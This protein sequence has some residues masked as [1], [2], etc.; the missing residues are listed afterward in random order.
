M[1]IYIFEN[2]SQTDAANFTTADSLLF[3][4]PTVSANT[5]T[6]T[7]STGGNLT[8]ITSAGKTLT[9]GGN[10]IANAAG[11]QFSDSSGAALDLAQNGNETVAGTTGA[12]VIYGFDGTDCIQADTGNDTLFGAAG[13]DTLLGQGGNDQLDGGSGVDQINGDTGND[14]IFGGTGADALTGLGGADHIYGFGLGADATAGDGADT[15]D[16]GDGNDYGQ[17]NLGNDTIEG[18]LGS[19][20]I[21][22]GADNDSITDAGD[23]NDTINGNKGDDRIESGVGNDFVRGGQGNDT[24]AG[25]D[26]NDFLLGDLGD[27][28]LSGGNGADQLQGGDGADQFIFAASATE[29]APVTDTVAGTADSVTSYDTI[30]DFLDGVDRIS[31]GGGAIGDDAG[32]VREGS[33]SVTFTKVSD[34]TVYAQQLLDSFAGN[35]DVAVVKVGSDTYL[36]FDGNSNDGT[37]DSIVKL[38]GITDTSKITI[39]DFL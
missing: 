7:N 33:S 17:G 18:G 25:G 30:L 16:L 14:F 28:S 23:G 11:I 39:A 38:Q 3:N 36:F 22:G 13:T 9:F 15:I 8:T 31:L 24:V 35:T 34:A 2:M 32:E 29:S 5:I 21:N 6:V 12:E 10:E 26:G 27:D 19:D 20:R 1:T 37:I 4:T